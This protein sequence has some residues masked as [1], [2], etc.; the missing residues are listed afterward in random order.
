M[1]QAVIQY[2]CIAKNKNVIVM[3]DSIS[4]KKKHLEMSTNNRLQYS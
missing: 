3:I 1:R 4:K 2:Y